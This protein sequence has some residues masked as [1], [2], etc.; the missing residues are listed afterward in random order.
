[1]TSSDLYL[2]TM[3]V[4]DYADRLRSCIKHSSDLLMETF[5]T[6]LKPVVL[7]GETE[8]TVV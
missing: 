2:G 8:H 6:Q 4:A 3:V 7:C 5:N 1:M